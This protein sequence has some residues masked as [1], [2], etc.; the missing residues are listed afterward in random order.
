MFKKVLNA[1]HMLYLCSTVTDS[2]A[3]DKPRMSFHV[4]KF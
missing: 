4:M 2:D 3:L 1:R